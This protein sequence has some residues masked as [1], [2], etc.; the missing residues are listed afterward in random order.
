MIGWIKPVCMINCDITDETISLTVSLNDIMELMKTYDVRFHADL[1]AEGIVGINT[2]HRYASITE[3]Y[4]SVGE[5][6]YLVLSIELDEGT[7]RQIE[8]SNLT[9]ILTINRS[10]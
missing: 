1:S 2:Q 5:S 6:H 4:S 8:C 9:D 7:E 10:T 3:I